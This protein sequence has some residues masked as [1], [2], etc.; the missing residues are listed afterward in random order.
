MPLNVAP[1]G[2]EALT[3]PVYSNAPILLY[4]PWSTA[5]VSLHSHVI[6][7]AA[8]QFNFYSSVFKQNKNY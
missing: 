1:M 3:V 2:I 8:T 4:S 5:G 6:T 7:C